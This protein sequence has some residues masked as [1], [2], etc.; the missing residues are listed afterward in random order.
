MTVWER[1]LTGHRILIR[2]ICS[3]KINIIFLFLSSLKQRTLNAL[4]KRQEIRGFQAYTADFLTKLKI[5]KYVENC[6]RYAWKLV[7]QTPPYLIQG[8]SVVLKSNVAFDPVYHQV[9]REFAS[10]EH[11]S[12]YI[13]FVVWP[14]LF[15]GSSGRV[16]RKTEVLLQSHWEHYKL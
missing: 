1:K 14:G 15:E 5:K 12:G 8:N 11:N 10:A 3:G 4:N 13:D 9:P 7:C 6:C 16:I 2:Y